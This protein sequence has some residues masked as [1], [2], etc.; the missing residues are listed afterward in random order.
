MRVNPDAVDAK[1]AQL[2]AIDAWHAIDDATQW[3][4]F[5]CFLRPP[6]SVVRLLRRRLLLFL[7]GLVLLLLLLHRG[8]LRLDARLPFF[9]G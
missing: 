9:I 2:Y 6:D 5:N 1:R 7:L 3:C 4:L 8:L